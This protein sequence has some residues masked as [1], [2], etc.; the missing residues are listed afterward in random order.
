MLK[1]L[2]SLDLGKS[3]QTHQALGS[4]IVQD[5]LD[6]KMQQL[7]MLGY[8][9]LFYHCLY[10]LSIMF[11]QNKWFILGWNVVEIILECV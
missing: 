11:C 6:Y 7:Q 3:R 1:T 9:Q 5:F 2:T 10:L 4:Q 8:G